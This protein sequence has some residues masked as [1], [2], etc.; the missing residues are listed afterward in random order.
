[1]RS[2]CI[3]IGV[4]CP[5]ALAVPH[6]CACLAQLSG[7]VCCRVARQRHVGGLAV[8]S[9]KM[10]TNQTHCCTTLAHHPLLMD[11]DH[12]SLV[13]AP[14]NPLSCPASWALAAQRY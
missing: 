2:C 4:G 9:C 1:M 10:N 6:M 5:P 8:L 14:H 7:G 3:G 11:C 13:L 12:R